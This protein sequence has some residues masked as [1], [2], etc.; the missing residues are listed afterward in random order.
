MCLHYPQDIRFTNTK[1]ADV[2]YAYNGQRI[3]FFD[4]SRSK[5]S[6]I[7]YEVIEDL[8]NGI[9]LNS[10]YE[11]SMEMFLASHIVCF[12]NFEPDETDG[13]SVFWQRL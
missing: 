1:S 12:S 6:H 5:E 3:V 9:Y 10:K 11:S 4:Y 2:K 8:K 7:N 13:M